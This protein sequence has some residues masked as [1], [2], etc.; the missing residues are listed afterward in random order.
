[1]TVSDET[2]G[3]TETVARV[4]QHVYF[5]T[6][7][8]VADMQS[9]SQRRAVS[10]ARHVAVYLT[11]ELACETYDEIGDYFNRD[12]AAMMHAQA[13]IAAECLAGGKTLDL[14]RRI[15]K[16][17]TGSEDR[18]TKP[19]WK[20]L[21]DEFCLHCGDGAEVLTDQP[22]GY[23][24]DMDPVRCVACGCPGQACADPD[25]SWINWHDEPDCTCDWCKVNYPQGNPPAGKGEP[26]DA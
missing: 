7:V 17:I 13:K 3:R 21:P 24:C 15:R 1:M 6:G 23:W 12:H 8:S 10:Q 9:P 11:Y 25:G 5:A 4:A 2:Y 19:I 18:I 16:L 14:V 26:D 20:T 22:P